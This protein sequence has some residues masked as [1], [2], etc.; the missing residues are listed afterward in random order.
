VRAFWGTV[1]WAE[2]RI[3]HV[4][5]EREFRPIFALVFAT[6]VVGS[7]FYRVVEGWGLLDAFY[8]SVV[9]L[10]TIGYGDFSPETKLGK[11][12]TIAYVFV[13]VLTWAALLNAVAKRS[14]VIAAGLDRPSGQRDETDR[15]SGDEPPN[16]T[17]G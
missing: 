6:L 13:G 4:A 1:W 14:V 3:L 15:Q 17:I 9:T 12:F 5:T 8:F 11:A 10:A 2:R 7:I 16:A